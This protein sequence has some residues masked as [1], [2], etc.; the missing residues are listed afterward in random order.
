[1][2]INLVFQLLTPFNTYKT[3]IIFPAIILI[4][5]NTLFLKTFKISHFELTLPGNTMHCIFMF[6]PLPSLQGILLLINI[7]SN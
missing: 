2:L 1:M 3:V 6:P 5:L 4:S 7:N